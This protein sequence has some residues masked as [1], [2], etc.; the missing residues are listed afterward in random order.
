MPQ[1]VPPPPITAEWGED[2][3]KQFFELL[4]KQINQ[5]PFFA[6]TTDPGTTGV[7][8]GSWGVWKNTTS[9]VVSLWVND[10][11]VMK[12]VVIS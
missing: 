3:W 12:S 8:N 2:V 4:R 6:S 5:P 11:G 10:G 9:G 7:P 1:L